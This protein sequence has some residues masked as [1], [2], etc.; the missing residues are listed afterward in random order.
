MDARAAIFRIRTIEFDWDDENFISITGPSFTVREKL[1]KLGAK[2]MDSNKTWVID[3]RDEEHRAK[4][5]G[6]LLM[7]QKDLQTSK[8]KKKQTKK[9]L[10]KEV[11]Q[12]GNDYAK[13]VIFTGDTYDYRKSIKFL[14]GKWID[15]HW[16]LEEKIDVSNLLEYFED[17]PVSLYLPHGHYEKDTMIITFDYLSDKHKIQPDCSCTDVI[18]CQLCKFACCKDVKIIERKGFSGLLYE[19]DVHGKQEY[20]TWD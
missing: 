2:W 13:N 5:L 7:I 16:K 3:V 9:Q 19:C 20:G 6:Y 17:V 18:T 15:G 1:K 4:T 8:K 14:G 11:F 10:K 12:I